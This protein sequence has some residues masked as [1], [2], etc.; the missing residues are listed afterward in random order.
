MA[1]RGNRYFA[2]AEGL[3]LSLKTITSGRA[4]YKVGRDERAMDD[5]GW[6]VVNEGQPYTIEIA[7]PVPVETFIVWFPRRWAEDAW[8]GATCGSGEL[9]TTPQANCDIGFYERYMPNENAVAPAARRLRTAL[10]TGRT[11]DNAWLEERLRELIT[12]ILNVQFDL[13]RQMSRLPALRA[14]TRE[15]LWRRLNRA[16]D[17][18]HAH[19]E[20]GPSLGDAARVAAMS[21]YHLL[22]TFQAAFGLTPHEWLT[23]CR[24]ER[25][26]FLLASTTVP[27]TEV[28][29]MIGYEGLGTFSAWFLRRT[30][31]SPSAWRQV[32]GRRTAIRKIREVLTPSG[33]VISSVIE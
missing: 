30:G 20:V 27:V 16:R 7:A 29:G 25:A 18:L 12:G 6:L 13:Q 32:H 33:L 24:V 22:R 9:L 17:F 8:R 15:E 19:C 4:R 3:P 5:N 31:V 28:C 21:P 11:A 2:E 14:A 1:G 23:A 26:K 10:A